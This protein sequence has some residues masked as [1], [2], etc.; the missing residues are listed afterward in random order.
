MCIPYRV[1]LCDCLLVDQSHCITPTK[2]MNA[3]WP[4]LYV[5]WCLVLFRIMFDMSSWTPILHLPYCE[6]CANSSF[7]LSYIVYVIVRYKRTH[8]TC[9][10]HRVMTA[11]C[12]WCVLCVCFATTLSLVRS[13]NPFELAT[14]VASSPLNATTLDLLLRTLRTL[15]A[16]SFHVKVQHHQLRLLGAVARTD[17]TDQ[18]RVVGTAQS[19]YTK[20]VSQAIIIALKP[21][22]I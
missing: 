14:T 12:V 8:I 7:F 17:R 2:L 21:I 5:C 1:C 3:L 18:L 6:E 22:G 19:K 16:R 10:S 11:Q 15:E 9:R 4:S 20:N 13:E